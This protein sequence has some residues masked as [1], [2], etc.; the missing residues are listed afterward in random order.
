MGSQ[1]FPPN[2]SAETPP[3]PNAPPRQTTVYDA[4]VAAVH[5]VWQV[6]RTLLLLLVVAAVIGL[7]E[8]WIR[9]TISE[10]LQPFGKWVWPITSFRDLLGLVIVALPVA[11]T[12][13]LR[14]LEGFLVYGVI[15]GF[16]LYRKSFQL[17]VGSTF[18]DDMPPKLRHPTGNLVSNLASYLVY[19]GNLIGLSTS[20]R[21]AYIMFDPAL[22]RL[23]NFLPEVLLG[24]VELYIEAS[25]LSEPMRDDEDTRTYNRRVEDEYRRLLFEDTHRTREHHGGPKFSCPTLFRLFGK[26]GDRIQAYLNAKRNL[27]LPPRF[28]TLVQFQSGFLAPAYLVSGLLHAFDEDWTRIM[29]GAEDD[30]TILQDSAGVDP[31]QKVAGLRK[32]QSFIWSC[33]AQWGPSIPICGSDQWRSDHLIALQFGYGDENNSLLLYRNGWGFDEWKLWLR[34]RPAGLGAA[35]PVNVSGNL[36]LS[37]CA[38]WNSEMAE[39]VRVRRPDLENLLCIDCQSIE[40]VGGGTLY[41]AY[42]WAMV[43]ICRREGERLSL[44]LPDPDRLQEHFQVRFPV[45]SAQRFPASTNWRHEWRALI[46]CFQH[47]NIADPDVLGDIKRELADK[48]VATLLRYRSEAERSGVDIS[49]A[50]VCCS[51]DNGDGSELLGE[52]GGRI[53]ELVKESLLRLTTPGESSATGAAS[54]NEDVESS[55]EQQ[56]IYVGRRTHTISLTAC[57]LPTIVD[58]YLT[59]VRCIS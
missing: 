30:H 55:W 18:P 54:W 31:L 20:R 27:G 5:L 28:R 37:S 41:S 47:G 34:S 35:C 21:L 4:V 43:A 17:L 16:G 42:V 29:A 23:A 48:T 11:I 33:W 24:K 22:F 14:F 38:E 1:D 9:P 26:N 39:A 36:R 44:V 57:H 50:V 40:H 49:F 13:L 58:H 52:P 46:P 53:R 19:Y 45:D 56:G 51:D 6:V 12:F 32:L 3:V 59:H 15:L 25:L 8:F 2:R 10:W 7:I